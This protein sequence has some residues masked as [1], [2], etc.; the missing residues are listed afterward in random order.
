MHHTEGPWV[1]VTQVL[2]PVVQ[3]SSRGGR[4]SCW[5]VNPLGEW[6]GFLQFLR[7]PL[8]NNSTHIG[9]LWRFHRIRKSRAQHSI[10]ESRSSITVTYYLFLPELVCQHREWL[11]I[12]KTHNRMAWM[13]EKLV[14][15]AQRDPQG[16]SQRWSPRSSGTQGTRLPFLRCDLHPHDPEDGIPTKGQ[17]VAVLLAPF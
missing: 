8:Q 1:K 14:S 4:V 2:P 12:I 17:M 10:W 3:V 15:L 7:S 6:A 9:L 5:G 13:R 16:E 11:W